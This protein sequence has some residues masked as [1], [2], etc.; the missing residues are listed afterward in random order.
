MMVVTF[1]SLTVDVILQTKCTD[2][3]V[4]SG[5]REDLCFEDDGAHEVDFIFPASILSAS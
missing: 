3:Q 1:A 4:E 2:G 5:S